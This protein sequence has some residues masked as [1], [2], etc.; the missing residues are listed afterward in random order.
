MQ[1]TTDH[2]G[3]QQQQQTAVR[4]HADLRRTHSPLYN[5]TALWARD[6]LRRDPH[7]SPGSS[8]STNPLNP[9]AVHERMVVARRRWTRSVCLGFLA[10]I[11]ANVASTVFV[12]VKLDSDGDL[13][14]D[15]LLQQ[16]MRQVS[17]L[18]ELRFCIPLDTK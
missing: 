11:L 16:F 13:T 12:F 17:R 8:S 14:D 18:I 3:P 7:A 4:P 6:L 10:C 1:S 2:D 15:A 5:Y 9:I